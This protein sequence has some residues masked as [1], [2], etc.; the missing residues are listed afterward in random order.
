MREIIIAA[1]VLCVLYG[2]YLHWEIAFVLLVIAGLYELH[3]RNILK[4]ISTKIGR[5]N[6][7]SSKHKASYLV[8]GALLLLAG[9]YY[10]T[11]SKHPKTY[12]IMVNHTVETRPPVDLRLTDTQDNERTKICEQGCLTMMQN[13]VFEQTMGEYYACVRACTR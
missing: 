11:E 7:L 3:S 13:K 2:L 1:I 9:G 8:A 12:P 5:L 4:N 10:L 6:H